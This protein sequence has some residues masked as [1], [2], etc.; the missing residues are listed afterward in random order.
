[1][2][3]T[4]ATRKI[5]AFIIVVL[6]GGVSPY[7]FLHVSPG[8]GQYFNSS[9]GSR[10]EGGAAAEELTHIL[11]GLG[12]DPSNL[13]ATVTST[14]TD[15]LISKALSSSGKGNTV[16]V[17]LSPRSPG[18]PVREVDARI[19]VSGD[20]AWLIGVEVECGS[21][22]CLERVWPRI[23][24]LLEERAQLYTGA[25]I[26]LL[27]VDEGGGSWEKISYIAVYQSL[28]A[29]IHLYSPDNG[30]EEPLRLEAYVRRDSGEVVFNDEIMG[31]PGIYSDSMEKL[32]PEISAGKAEEIARRWVSPHFPGASA[33]T[34][35]RPV[36]LLDVSRIGSATL[37]YE[38]NYTLANGTT[39]KTMVNASGDG[40]WGYISGRQVLSGD[41]G[42]E[43][44][45]P[46]GGA[47]LKVWLLAGAAVSSFFAFVGF[48]LR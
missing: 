44:P 9:L 34:V 13:K 22:G 28:N 12:V 17:T 32:T 27:R 16:L 35:V 15:T 3:E 8:G 47:G 46:S 26:E 5:I 29:T 20:N 25:N 41:R 36:V 23:T 1:M 7:I 31:L 45:P 24:A 2:G 10:R 30:W 40:V 18:L 48:K 6:V 19:L 43:G 37:V 21:A 14:G 4:V 42:V 38:Q 33:S 11:S 39:L